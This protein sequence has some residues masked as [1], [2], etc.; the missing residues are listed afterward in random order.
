M[1]K[2]F[3]FCIAIFLIA[4]LKAKKS[5]YDVSSPTGILPIVVVGQGFLFGNNSSQNQSVPRNPPAALSFTDTDVLNFGKIGGAILISKAIDESDIEK[6]NLYFGTSGTIKYNSS[7]IQ[8]LPKTGSDL[9]FQLS[10]N[11]SIPSGVTHILA[12]S[13]N[14]FGENST[15][16]SVQIKNLEKNGKYLYVYDSSANLKYFTISAGGVLSPITSYTIGSATIRSVSIDSSGKYLF[17]AAGNSI[18]PRL[19]NTSDGSLQAA[20]FT[21]YISI[22]SAVADAAGLF[23]Y[24]S[25]S[26]AG[27][28]EFSSFSVNQSTATL[29]LVQNSP[30]SVGATVSSSIFLDRTGK[31]AF[32]IRA[33]GDSNLYSYAINSSNGGIISSFQNTGLPLAQNFMVSHPS[34]DIMYLATG[35]VIYA[36]S[37]NQTTGA[38]GS[39]GSLSV[40]PSGLRGMVIEKTGKWLYAVSSTANTVYK[41][42]LNS[43]GTLISASTAATG[44]NS[45]VAV[46]SD[47]SGRFLFIGDSVNTRSYQ[48]N[49]SDGSLSIISTI[50]GSTAVATGMAISSYIE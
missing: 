36:Y 25:T 22:Q 8:S 27:S 14:S 10:E 19:I 43:A 3:L 32:V 45:P 18:L 44:L 48:I 49:S 23:V 29:S 6:Y 33:T 13:S 38:L 37:V 30:F 24:A 34:L 21:N 16:A 50:A 41:V 11:T 7:T 28:F 39:I 26:N 42:D 17:C 12:Y 5:P 31:F 35:T 2:L 15:P 4:C 9:T 46:L 40:A 1:K 20:T 47:P